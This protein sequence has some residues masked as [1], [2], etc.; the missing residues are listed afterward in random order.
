P[1]S[2]SPPAFHGQLVSLLK[3]HPSFLFQLWRGAEWSTSKQ[4]RAACT[5]IESAA[6]ASKEVDSKPSVP[7]GDLTPSH[8]VTETE[9]TE[10]P[11]SIVL[12]SLLWQHRKWRDP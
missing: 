2:A 7:A 10:R 9:N 12:L 6:G 4:T 1:P 11:L 3:A 5:V 8:Q